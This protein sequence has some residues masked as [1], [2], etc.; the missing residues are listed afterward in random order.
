MTLKSFGLA[1]T[2]ILLLPTA[3]QAQDQ[4]QVSFRNDVGRA[5]SCG[6]RRAG[7]SAIETFTIRTGETWSKTYSG[8]KARL[9]V[10]EGTFPHWQPLALDGSYR[11]VRAID[12][13]IVAE[14]MR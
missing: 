5:I 8:S 3:S 9:I 10:C 1:G 7:S 4:H 6:I 2:A 12:E 11:L 14:P 13:R